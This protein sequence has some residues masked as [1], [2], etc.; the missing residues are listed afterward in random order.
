MN[1]DFIYEALPTRVIFG[2]GKLQSLPH[3]V[4]RLGARR[5][6]V[7]STPQQ[8]PWAQNVSELLGSVSAGIYS[9]ATMHT[10]VE[11]SE[12]AVAQV[13]RLE[14]DCVV[15]LGGGSTTGLG[16]AIALRTGLPQIA[17]PTT[18]AGSEMTPI[19]GETENGVKTTKRL[20]VILPKTVI[21]D[22]DLSLTLPA[23]LSA[24]SGLNAMAH[25]V[26]ALYAQDRNPVTSIM[27]EEGLAAF[28]RALPTI[29]QSPKDLEARSDALYGA[30][31]CGICLASAGM[32]LHHKLCHVLGGA[33]DL[34][35]AQTHAVMLPHTAAYNSKAAADAMQRIARALNAPDAAQGLWDL[36]GKLGAPRSLKELG[37]PETGIELATELALKNPYWNPRPLEADGIRKLLAR[38]WAGE[39]PSL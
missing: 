12:Q 22:V 29:T 24:T 9:N 32:A 20:P 36:A 13:Q 35:H 25:A 34:P 28:A 15:A 30:W 1:H 6:L 16:K 37:M 23:A 2:Q 27:A 10:P 19:L 33:F 26:E 4:E 8:E 17:V 39:A 31:L 7:L 11:I 21:Y 3:E 14:A 18:Y 5:V 38:A